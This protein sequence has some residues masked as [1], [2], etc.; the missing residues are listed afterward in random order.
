M[1]NGMTIQEACRALMN[2]EV[3]LKTEQIRIEDAYDRVLAEKIMADIAVPSFRR[4]A[5][6]GYALR[7]A[8]I[9]DASPTHPVT[10]KV[11]EVIPAG[12]V[13]RYPVT[14]GTAARIMTGAKVPA[15]ADAV[16]K[17]EDTQ[18]TEGEVRLSR[19]VHAGNIVEIGEDVKQGAC[20]IEPGKVVTAADAA[21]MAG[22]GREYVCV[23]RKPEVAILST[24]SELLEQGQRLKEGKVYNTNRY[25]LGGY[26][27]KYGMVPRNCGIVEDD[28]RTLAD[29]ITEALQVSDM[30]LTT[31][32]VSA[33]DFDHIPK[34]LEEI[35]AGLLFHKLPFKPGGAMLAAVKDGKI[36]LG[37]SGNPGAAAVG[38]LRVGLPYMKKLC[39]RKDIPLVESEAVLAEA[40][41]KPSRGIRILRGR[42]EIIDGELVFHLLEHQ[43]NGA[44]SSMMDCDLLGEI[45]AG[46][47]ALPAGTRLRVF[48]V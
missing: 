18:F 2:L 47:E 39:G 33:G 13:G 14:A 24:G 29:R 45:P 32:G 40:F 21:V 35:G 4:S 16:V 43:E 1:G 44:V 12:S 20:L 22:Q 42:A 19:P 5:Y 3:S 6:D 36:I 34:A 48:F 28:I 41:P 7:S 17:H 38:L 37:L 27:K 11:T 26:L 10:L 23:Y 15:G 9:A 46:S 30:V 25:L 31:G 8:D